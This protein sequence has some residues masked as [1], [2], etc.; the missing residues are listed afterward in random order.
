MSKQV[1]FKDL[2]N[3]EIHGGILLDNGDVICGDCGGIKEDAD[4]GTTWELLKI[5]PC[6][7]SLDLEICGD[8][9]FMDDSNNVPII[10]C[11]CK[12]CDGFIEVSGCRGAC[13]P[14][15]DACDGTALGNECL[16]GS[17]GYQIQAVWDGNK[18]VIT[19]DAYPF[20]NKTDK[21]AK[22]IVEYI[23]SQPEDNTMSEGIRVLRSELQDFLNDNDLSD[24]EG[25]ELSLRKVV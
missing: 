2:L 22:E 11:R 5:F 10:L 20:Y 12:D 25:V 6:W 4:R 1:K 15:G 3:N 16:H 13:F 21:S 23:M 19:S 14:N 18:E 9:L 24:F 8:E 7:S 17:L